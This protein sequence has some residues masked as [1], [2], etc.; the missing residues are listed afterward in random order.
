MV[1][2]ERSTMSLIQFYSRLG[3]LLPVAVTGSPDAICA[4][5]IAAL[6]PNA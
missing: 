5:T 2:Y 1:A 4:R 6:T 3:L